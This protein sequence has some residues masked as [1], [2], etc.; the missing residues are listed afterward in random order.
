MRVL[1]DLSSNAILQVE[2]SR[3]IGEVTKINGKYP[4]EVPAGTIDVGISSYMLPVDGGDITSLAYQQLQNRFP[5]FPHIVFNPLLESTDQAFFDLSATLDN[6]TNAV[7]PSPYTGTFSVRA[8]MGREVPPAGLTPLSLA[9]LPPNIY[10]TPPKPGLLITDVIDISSVTGGLGATDV[11]VYWKV[12]QMTV[13]DDV[14]SDYGVL[15]GT[16]S[17]AIKSLTEIDPDLSGFVAAISVDGGIIYQP[18]SHLTPLSFCIAGTE[19]RLA[20]LNTTAEKIYLATYAIL[21]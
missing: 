4:V 7:L 12:Y 17:P 20:F 8:Q 1:A 11:M 10:T 16:N 13:T 6:S 3:N 15:S 9:L 19:I 2:R 14:M 21:F 18:L 5:Q